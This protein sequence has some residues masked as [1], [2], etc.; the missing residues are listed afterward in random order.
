MSM[1]KNG[2]GE[3]AGVGHNSQTLRE[4]GKA[5]V[6]RIENLEAEIDRETEEFKD[7]LLAP[8]KH[9]VKAVYE[10]AKAAGLTK[11][12]VKALVAAR[13]KERQV[14]KARAALDIADQSVFDNIRLALGD[15]ADTAL[16]KSALGEAQ[17][18]ATQATA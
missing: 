11:K 1:A 16:G 14:A 8:L 5:F 2:N 13:K 6:E 3:G 4:Q 10:E 18:T 15:Y 7:T 17:T 9:D 12:S